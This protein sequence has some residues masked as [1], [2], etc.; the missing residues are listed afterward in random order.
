FLGLPNIDAGAFLGLPGAPPNKETEW[1]ADGTADVT[2]MASV[3]KPSI[4][5]IK[6][7]FGPAA[8]W[9][10]LQPFRL[11]L[12]EGADPPAWDP[13]TRMLTVSLPKGETV[14]LR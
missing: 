12:R 14:R 6:V 4:T 8:D 11:R 1:H 13:A 10:K 5:L 2:D 9:P 7:D 3:E